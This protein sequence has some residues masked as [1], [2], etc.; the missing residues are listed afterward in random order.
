MKVHH[1][2]YRE[3]IEYTANLNLPWEKFEN[4]SILITGARGLI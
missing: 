4:S 1:E 2:M 3:D